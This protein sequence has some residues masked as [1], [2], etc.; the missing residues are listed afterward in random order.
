MSTSVFGQLNMYT[1]EIGLGFV[2]LFLAFLVYFFWKS[3]IDFKKRIVLISLLSCFFIFNNLSL[4]AVG[5]VVGLPIYYRFFWAVPVLIIISKGLVDAVCWKIKRQYKAVII[6]FVV[7]IVLF[8]GNTTAIGRDHFRL[9]ANAFHISD[10]VIDA[11]HIMRDVKSVERPMIIGT[12]EIMQR[13]KQYDGSFVWGIGREPYREIY[14]R[15]YDAPGLDTSNHTIIRAVELGILDYDVL[16]AFKDVLERRDVEFIITFTEFRLDSKM[17]YLGFYP[18][19][20]TRQYTVFQRVVN[21][22]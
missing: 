4:R 16:G 9:P 3:N 14:R 18:V 19:G 2:V 10:D 6:A 13:I 5:N 15:G 7:L 20:Y 11:A 17:E 8:A 21:F 22:D 1:R 12:V